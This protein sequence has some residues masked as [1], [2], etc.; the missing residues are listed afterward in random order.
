VAF[1]LD[2]QKL[3]GFHFNARK[4]ADDDLIVG[5]TNPYELFLIF[6]Q[7]LAAERDRA[8]P[9]VRRTAENIAYMI[10]QSHNIEPKIPAMIRSVLN[11]QVQFAK[12]LLVNWDE[13]A[14]A[15]KAND[16]L[17]AEACVREAFEQ[18]VHPLLVSLR[19]EKGLPVDPMKAYLTG[20]HAKE[21]LKRGSGGASW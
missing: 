4:Y 12:A 17:A 15:Q 1:L 13:L 5:S 9:G 19:E 3:G 18:D 16:V 6:H 21:I 8:N 10:D 7:I 20:S 2:E 14:A 11:C